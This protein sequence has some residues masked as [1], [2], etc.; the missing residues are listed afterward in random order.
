MMRIAW[1]FTLFILNS[2]KPI[3]D[4]ESCGYE[5]CNKVDPS[6][7][8]VHLVPHSHDDVG[9]LK[10]VDQYYYGA[11]N[12]IQPAGVQH[13]IGSV[14]QALQKDSTRRFIQVET[15]F[16][17]Q[18][19]QDQPEK[20]KE[21]TRQLVNRG[22]LEIV[23]AAWSM[24]DEAAAHYHSIIDQFTWGLKR[25]NDTLGKCGRPKIGWQID[26]FGHSK[27]MASIFSQIGYEG[28]FFARLDYRDSKKRH[29]NKDL[30]LI[31]QG[32]SDLGNFSNIFTGV[33]YDFYTAP[34]YFCWDILCGDRPIIDNEKSFDYNVNTVVHEFADY[35]TKGIEY[36]KTNNLL[37]TMGGDFTYQAAEM[38]F[39]NMDK[40]IAGFK[41]YRPDINVLYST[42]SCYLKA[43][44]EEGRIKNIK[45]QLKTD[46]F[47]P[48]ASGIHSYWTGYFTSRPNSKRFERQGN[49]LLQ[50]MKQ[51]TSFAKYGH[52]LNFENN[53]IPLKE[54][55]GIMQHHDAITGT[56]KQHVAQDYVRLLTAAVNTAEEDVDSIILNILKKTDNADDAKIKFSS[57]LMA[58]VSHCE[59]SN[60]DRFTVVVYNPLSR[61][62][63]HYVRLPVNGNSYT[64]VGPDG[65]VNYEILPT[66]ADFSYV[67]SITPSK[68]ELV[69]VAENLPPLGLKYFYIQM[70]KSTRKKHKIVKQTRFGNNNSGFTIDKVTGLL[71]SVTLNGVTI[72]LSQ[73]F[74][75]YNGANG[76]TFRASG[77]YIFRPANTTPTAAS[78]AKTITYTT[79]ATDIVDEVHQIF[80]N[81]IRQIIR[82]Y[83]N[84]NY[85]EFD[86]LVGPIALINDLGVEVVT[87]FVTKRLSNGV[88][89]TDSNGK[90]MVKRIRNFRE[91]YTYTNEEPI[92]GNYYPITSCILL[93]DGGSD[94]CSQGDNLEIAVLNDRAQGGSSLEDGQMELMIHRR[95]L[96]DDNFGVGE[97]LNEIEFN[98]GV[99][100]RGQ[101]YLTFG[102]KNT[103]SKSSVKSAA[104]NQRDI[105]QRKL[106]SPW[107]FVG[108]ATSNQHSL[109]NLQAKLNFQFSGLAT[110][111]P[112]N[113]TNDKATILLR[114]EHIFSKDEDNVL[115][116]PATL[117]I[118]NLFP[119]FNI[120]NIEEMSLAAHMPKIEI[121]KMTWNSFIPATPS[122]EVRSTDLNIDLEPME[123]RTFIVE[124]V[125]KTRNFV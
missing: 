85:I 44:N 53:L 89:Y 108:D 109:Q 28:V 116:Q 43:V 13:I 38:Y 46:D 97:P 40:L 17:W 106:L 34:A 65:N 93:K 24:N 4:S 119:L 66:I 123:I 92:S 54:V 102:R 41:K 49:N 118:G 57:C 25:I 76:E 105:A 35:V 94:N 2:A 71:S 7:I 10:T 32:S 124:V 115:S 29:L 50:V 74:M 122:R 107:V 36:Y 55:M 117:N 77:A 67:D 62:V 48:Y 80:N 114:L 27:E 30:E 84:E 8:N 120:I 16:F 5:S 70:S 56:E 3:K 98:E 121:E 101:H 52:N 110:A 79:Y 59:K 72:E 104:A 20:T 64:I 68:K 87:R 73:N 22:R 96:N 45:F 81:W 31:W 39:T 18:W 21:M 33:L 113:N 78:F 9:W 11:K 88:F 112:N 95:L 47:F 58:N 15:A 125:P 61:Y 12:Y 111:L 1:L 19:W 90:Q 100:V 69:F 99:V 42:P 86:W 60:L 6:K 83:K 37:I 91:M 63:N 23:N 82:V 75:F 26:P 103:C 14:V 51:T